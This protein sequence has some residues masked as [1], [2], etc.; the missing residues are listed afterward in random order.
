[1]DSGTG[2]LDQS[3]ES[4]VSDEER[5]EKGVREGITADCITLGHENINGVCFE[6]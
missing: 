6:N 1:M 3:M 4:A 2:I 5:M